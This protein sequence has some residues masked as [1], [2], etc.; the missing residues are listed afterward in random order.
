MLEGAPL[1]IEL[2]A[3]QVRTMCIE[4]IV[5]HLRK[6]RLDF[7][8]GGRHAGPS[9]HHTLRATIDWSYS[10]LSPEE[11][12]LLSRLSVFA[13][14]WSLEAMEG[15]VGGTPALLGALVDKSLVTFSPNG[16]YALLETVRQYAGEKLPANARALVEADFGSWYADYI[17][18]LGR[19]GPQMAPLAF[20]AQVELDLPNFRAAIES[21]ECDSS[22]R[23]RIAG[24]LGIYWTRRLARSEGIHY[25][26]YALDHD[27]DRQPGALRAE[28]LFILAVLVRDSDKA[29]SAEASIESLRLFRQ[30][31][32]AVG[33]IKVLRQMA[34]HRYVNGDFAKS[35]EL[36]EE[37]L[38]IAQ[39]G[40]DRWLI[41]LCAGGLSTV[42]APLGDYRRAIALCIEAIS[43]F[44]EINDTYCLSWSLRSMGLLNFDL[45][46]FQ[47]MKRCNEE[48]LEIFRACD[49]REGIAWCLA[50]LGRANTES[51]QPNIGQEQ[52]Q[53]SRQ[54]F[55]AANELLPSASAGEGLARNSIV[56]GRPEE[57]E[58][59]LSES[60]SV[61]LSS[62]HRLGIARVLD[63]LGDIQAD[64]AVSEKRYKESL[65][66]WQDVGDLKS[67]RLSLLRLGAIAFDR[68]ELSRSAKLGAHSVQ[69]GTRIEL[70]LPGG[71]EAIS[72]YLKDV[73]ASHPADW[74]AGRHLETSDA[75]NLAL[76]L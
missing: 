17:E 2:A 71:F 10:L 73:K 75:V 50:D 43:I 24:A 74:E 5:Q 13:G 30:F 22:V 54:I 25:L 72:A 21:L 40:N 58:R 32:D 66:V 15:I 23:L 39:S 64:P 11:R 27:M 41:A 1:A 61:Y 51:G 19:V 7:L 46:D 29:L 16:R 56:L 59:L 53:E 48:A 6:H 70:P 57:A 52:I 12:G 55:R 76:E 18:R 35:K 34:L 37:A 9:R 45:S 63:C 14:S 65:T 28:A 8:T 68:G 33:A 20:F 31:E 36:Y 3:C 4:Q 67:I 62:K 26:K 60:L 44:R 38:A 49:S 69:L 47:S 42:V